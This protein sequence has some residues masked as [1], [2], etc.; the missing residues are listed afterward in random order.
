MK[1][2]KGG[3]REKIEKKYINS[4]KEKG[5]VK[6]VEGIKKEKK[7]KKKRNRKNRKKGKI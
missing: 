1:R 3:K 5:G 2:R 4:S 6:C 7:R